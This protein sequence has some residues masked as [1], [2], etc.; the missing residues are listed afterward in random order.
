M[1]KKSLRGAVFV[2]IAN[3]DSPGLTG[4]RLEPQL[5]RPLTVKAVCGGTLGWKDPSFNSMLTLP[6]ATHQ[7]PNP[8]DLI[9]Y[10]FILKFNSPYG[11][12]GPMIIKTT[13]LLYIKETYSDNSKIGPFPIEKYMKNVPAS[14][15]EIQRFQ[16]KKEFFPKNK[17]C[18]L[19][20]DSYK[21]ASNSTSRNDS[22]QNYNSQIEKWQRSPERIVNRTKTPGRKVYLPVQKVKYI[23][24]HS[25]L[26]SKI[27]LE[28]TT[29]FLAIERLRLWQGTEL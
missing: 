6:G 22:C 5:G 17:M 8:N 16:I 2:I 24:V 21:R 23:L 4:G 19:R 12:T 20:N 1:N 11:P 26:E 13:V 18:R 9:K 15:L 28:I 7:D 10:L 25:Y 27:P 29:D 14:L 3:K